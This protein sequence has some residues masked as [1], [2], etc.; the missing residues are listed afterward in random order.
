MN[1]LLAVGCSITHGLETVSTNYDVANT[2]F[3]YARYLADYYQAEY[4]NIAYPGA[5]NEMIF[6]RIVEH[7]PTQPY[8]HLVVGWTGLHREAWEKNNVTWTF[9]LNYG[10]CT[11]NNISELPFIKRHPIAH[12]CSN[13]KELVKQVQQFWEVVKIKLLNDSQEQKLTHYRS[14]VQ[15]LCQ[16]HNIQL[17]EI[18]VLP[19]EQHDLFSVTNIGDWFQT[20]RHP[21]QSEHKLIYQHIVSHNEKI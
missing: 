9:N 1:K 20:G 19:N 12:L 7:L 17:L 8:T 11:D 15:M 13:R 16:H 18:S 10:Q 4:F 5:S 6:H 2:E 14:I 21:T 3:S